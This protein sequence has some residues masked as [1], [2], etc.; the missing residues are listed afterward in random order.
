MLAADSLIFERRFR[1]TRQLFLEM[2]DQGA[3][4]DLRLELVKGEL[5]VRRSMGVPHAR[6]IEELSELLVPALVRRARVRVQLPLNVD[7]ES[8]LVPDLAV[9]DR[10]ASKEDH[11]WTALLVIEVSDSSARFDRIVK[12]PLYAQAAV[13]AYWQF[14]LQ[15]RAVEV[16]S[17]PREGAWGR[18]TR[19]SRGRLGV[20]GFPDVEVDVDHLFR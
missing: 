17:E 16:F 9:V 15:K 3:F 19:V 14:D 13:G 20:P 6:V 1:W 18:T 7:D 5:V 12:A 10:Q 11:P 2:A 4:G 8:L